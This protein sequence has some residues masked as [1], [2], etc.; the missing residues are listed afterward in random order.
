MCFVLVWRRG[1]FIFRRSRCRMFFNCL[2]RVEFFVRFFLYGFL[3][4]LDFGCYFFRLDREI[5]EF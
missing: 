4:G 3:G 1:G 5:G 2:F